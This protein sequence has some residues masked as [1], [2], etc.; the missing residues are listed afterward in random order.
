MEELKDIIK[1]LSEE[2]QKNFFDK[3]KQQA[4]SAAKTAAERKKKEEEKK[5][6]KASGHWESEDNEIKMTADI[7]EEEKDKIEFTVG[8]IDEPIKFSMSKNEFFNFFKMLEE[9]HSFVK[10][11]E[12]KHTD[13][14]WQKY[15]TDIANA[16]SSST[17]DLRDYRPRRRNS[18]FYI[19]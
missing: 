13:Y 8:K 2:E 15:L 5:K 12:E 16:I 19:R 17:S 6:F 7:K 4:Q 3:V 9:V 18:I 10:E 11:E 14:S 1:N